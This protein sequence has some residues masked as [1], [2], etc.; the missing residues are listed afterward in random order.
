MVE[1]LS[2]SQIKHMLTILKCL[3]K[4]STHSNMIRT[5]I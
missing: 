3:L 5:D 2:I 1:L 4:S